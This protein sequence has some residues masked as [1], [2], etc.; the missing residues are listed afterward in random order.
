[1][2]SIQMQDSP[3]KVKLARNAEVEHERCDHELCELAERTQVRWILRKMQVNEAV[4]NQMEQASDDPPHTD[5]V[6]QG[7]V[8][9]IIR[10]NEC[11]IIDDRVQLKADVG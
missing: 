3:D 4:Q 2:K 9:I 6:D 7:C 8:A 1:M 5:F 10:A 11:R